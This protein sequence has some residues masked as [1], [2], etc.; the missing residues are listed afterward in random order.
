MYRNE[1]DHA[2]NDYNISKVTAAIA[3][4]LMLMIFSGFMYLERLREKRECH[5][6]DGNKTVNGTLVQIVDNDT[7]IQT[8]SA[9]VLIHGK[10]KITMTGTGKN[11]I[12][13]NGGTLNIRR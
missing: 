7:L 3:A 5:T 11:I 4:V 8:D 9:N 2:R 6:T 13:K 12:V 10:D 1:Y